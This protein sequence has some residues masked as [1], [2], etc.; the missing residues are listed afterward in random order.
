M[1]R[2]RW[3][4]TWTLTH[5]LQRG[6]AALATMLVLSSEAAAIRELAGLLTKV[7]AEGSCGNIRWPTAPGDEG[8]ATHMTGRVGIARANDSG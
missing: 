6:F 2:G 4:S 8:H 3:D 1:Y 7:L 5:Y